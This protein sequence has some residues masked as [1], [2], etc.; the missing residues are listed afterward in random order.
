MFDA[1]IGSENVEERI[2]MKSPICCQILMFLERYCQWQCRRWTRYKKG[3]GYSS[4][5]NDELER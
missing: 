4:C 3:Q 1:G 2:S 5:S